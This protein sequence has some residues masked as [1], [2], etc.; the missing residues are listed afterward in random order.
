MWWWV[1][2]QLMELDISD[3]LA[4]NLNFCWSQWINHAEKRQIKIQNGGRKWNSDNEKSKQANRDSTGR[5]IK[6]CE[7]LLLLLVSQNRE[8]CKKDFNFV[9][10]NVQTGIAII[11]VR[12]GLAPTSRVVRSKSSKPLKQLC[13]PLFLCGSGGNSFRQGQAASPN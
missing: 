8:Y 1:N 7:F 12:L 9:T 3:L 5:G 11:D 4:S 10:M 13:A 6:I 2:K